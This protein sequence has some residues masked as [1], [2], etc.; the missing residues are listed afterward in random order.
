MSM[1]GYL[2]VFQKIMKKKKNGREK[3]IIFAHPK[4]W[5]AIRDLV[6]L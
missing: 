6:Y 1:A 4:L 5:H 2:E 3:I